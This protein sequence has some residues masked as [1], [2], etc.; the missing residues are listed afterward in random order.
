MRIGSRVSVAFYDD[1]E[2][3]VPALASIGT[4][5][6]VKYEHDGDGYQG[7]DWVS[8]RWADGRVRNLKLH[9]EDES[10]DWELVDVTPLHYA[11]LYLEYRAYAGPEEGGQWY[12]IHTPYDDGDCNGDS[13]PPAHGHFPT[14]EEAEKAKDALNAWCEQENRH[15]REP[16]SVLSEGHY[17]VYLEA[18]P[19]EPMPA[20]KP[21]YC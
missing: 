21:H 6:A 18:W 10:G 17:R 4:V 19:A 3:I 15:R 20:R 11:N 9:G 7:I 14:A 16:S 13:P 1:G 8:V 2:Y 12:D 5:I